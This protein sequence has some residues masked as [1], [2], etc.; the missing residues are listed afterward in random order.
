MADGLSFLLSLPSSSFLPF[1]HRTYLL[2][3]SALFLTGE[4][5]WP[6]KGYAWWSNQ[7]PE[8]DSPESTPDALPRWGPVQRGGC[9][10][11]LHH[12]AAEEARQR[13]GVEYCWQEVCWRELTQGPFETDCSLNRM[14]RWL[15][16][17]HCRYCKSVCWRVRE[18]SA[19]DALHPEEK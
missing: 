15:A 1:Y 17:C 18:S 16:F 6:E 8:T 13:P 7:C 9:V 10:W 11:H 14:Y 5:Y 19:R 2:T 3:L 12:W 4:W